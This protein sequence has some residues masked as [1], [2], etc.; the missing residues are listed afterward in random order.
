MYEEFFQFKKRP[1]APVGPVDSFA[2]IGPFR[3]AFELLQ[4]SLHQGQAVILLIGPSGSGKSHLCRFLAVNGGTKYKAVYLS[5][6]GFHTRRALLQAILY[7]IGRSY[8]GLSEQESR[9]QILEYVRDL[10]SGGQKLLLV[11]DEGQLLSPK[12]F[13]ELRTLIDHTPTGEQ[14]IQLV[15]SGT[16]E[17]EEHLFDPELQTFN[18]RIGAHVMLEPLSIQES[19]DYLFARL[20]WS[21][22]EMPETIF[23]EAAVNLICRAADGNVRCLNQLADHALLVAY[24]NEIQ[25]V[26]EVEVRRALDDLK[27]LPLHFQ[28]VGHGGSDADQQ[29]QE[30]MSG[31]PPIDPDATDEWELDILFGRPEGINEPTHVAMDDGQAH[32]IINGEV[33]LTVDPP[34]LEP[35]EPPVAMTVFEVGADMTVESIETPEARTIDAELNEVAIDDRY[36]RLDDEFQRA[37]GLIAEISWQQLRPELPAAEFPEPLLPAVNGVSAQDVED[38]LLELVEGIREDL[39]VHR[40]DAS[41]AAPEKADAIEDDGSWLEYDVIQPSPLV[42]PQVAPQTASRPHVDFRPVVTTTAPVQEVA[43]PAEQSSEEPSL[44]TLLFDRLRWRR[45]NLQS[46]K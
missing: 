18:Q 5:T 36:A 22:P 10:Q 19:V 24:V 16:T 1:F 31:R 12:L 17:V 23:T 21:E 7:E 4:R 46:K 8:V 38:S 26:T 33:E 34:A 43:V 28:A 3:D 15:I 42:D 27:I 11:L 14:Q 20:R 44:Y 29:E 40:I 45:R 37:D 13:E 30:P 32:G 25:P 35:E 9:L 41:T 2:L 6:S 39:A